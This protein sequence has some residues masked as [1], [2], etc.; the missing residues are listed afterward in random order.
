MKGDRFTAALFGVNAAL[1]LVLALLWLGV[2]PLA[3]W[4]DWSKPAPQPPSLDDV[5]S[6]VLR[7]NP[8]AAA[9]YP[10]VLERPLLLPWR[11]PEVLAT[12]T[13]TAP[14][15]AIEQLK[16]LG[17]VSGP[18]LTGVLL[19]E[20]AK[21]RFVRRGE[22]VGDWTFSAVEGRKAVFTKGAERKLM[23][24]PQLG[25]AAGAANVPGGP[26]A[27]QAVPP[28]TARPPAV[29]PTAVAPTAR[30]K[31]PAPPS[32]VPAPAPN[33]SEPVAAFGG[34]VAPTPPAAPKA[35]R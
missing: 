35:G 26:L 28:P 12:S 10:V 8:S 22:S 3:R 18:T 21:P 1:V 29:A 2:G 7:F 31:P 23:E 16:L 13:P 25:M 6:A 5:Q 19:E 20:Q 33:A 14:P 24:L 11:R 30:P 27:A 17:L 15:A 32:V 9:V 34:S 4:H